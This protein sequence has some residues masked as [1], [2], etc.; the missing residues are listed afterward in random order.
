M[1]PAPE[2]NIV[3]LITGDPLKNHRPAE[4][5]R[6]ALGL[7]SGGKGR[8]TIILRGPAARLLTDEV[9]EA[10]DGEELADRYLPVFKEWGTTFLVDETGAGHLSR[11]STDFP[12]RMLTETQIAAELAAADRVLIF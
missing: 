10:V 6:I 4:A 9:E 5:V 7:D 8:M 12:H 2:A 11:V 1:P 3:M